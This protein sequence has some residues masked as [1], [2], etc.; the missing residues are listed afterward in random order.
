MHFIFFVLSIHINVELTSG[1]ENRETNHKYKR[2][3]IP[4]H[5]RYRNFE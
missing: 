3:M 4:S 1:S 2:Q 5:Q